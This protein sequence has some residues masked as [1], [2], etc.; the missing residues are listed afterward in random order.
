[1]AKRRS[2][3]PSK[4]EQHIYFTTQEHVDLDTQD[5]M[6]KRFLMITEESVL[7]DEIEQLTLRLKAVK[8]RKVK[9]AGEILR[10]RRLWIGVRWDAKLVATIQKNE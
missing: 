5:I 2:T 1:M 9:K 3:R 7:D 10:C 8:A 6:R 4:T